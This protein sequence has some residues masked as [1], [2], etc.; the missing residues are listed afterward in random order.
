M[1]LICFDGMKEGY[2]S[3]IIYSKCFVS[4]DVCIIEVNTLDVY[5]RITFTRYMYKGIKEKRYNKVLIVH[6]LL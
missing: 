3:R 2:V 4:F 5:M 6:T 1:H